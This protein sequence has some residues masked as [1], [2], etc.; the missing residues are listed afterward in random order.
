MLG[1]SVGVRSEIGRGSEF[2][3]RIPLRYGAEEP[4]P[5]PATGFPEWTPDREELPVLVVEDSPEMMLMYRSYLASSGFAMLPASTTREAEEILE[6]IRP[7]AIVLDVILRAED[8]WAL[9]A[10]LK[11]DARTRDIPVLIASTIEDRNKAFHL[12]V[13]AWL[14][15]PFEQADLL[16]ELRILTGEAATRR[17]LLIDDQERDRYLLKQRMRGLSLLIMEAAGGVEGLHLAT[18]TRPD[19][20]F[21]DLTMPDLSGADVLDRL[22]QDPDLAGIPVVIATSRPL[23][24]HE[25]ERL[26]RKVFAI[27]GKDQLEQTDFADLLRRAAVRKSP[28]SNPLESE[29]PV[30]NRS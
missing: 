5:D 19:V 28:S 16:R 2:S 23:S 13:D 3:L 7:V 9:A 6:R 11:Q 4:V 20:I 29:V 17:V 18:R 14:L 8:T 25:R 1:G 27:L 21:L 12:G 24:A 22:A 30:W 10:R 26:G 15:K